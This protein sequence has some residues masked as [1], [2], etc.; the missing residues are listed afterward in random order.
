[1]SVF[2]LLISHTINTESS[3]PVNDKFS[4][5]HPRKKSLTLVWYRYQLFLVD[6]GAFINNVR[7]GGRGLTY[8]KMPRLRE[9][10]SIYEW[11]LITDM[12]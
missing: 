3:F 10:Y 12:K 11:T 7:W 9:R 2:Y 8:L 5:G 4:I 1:M 6:K